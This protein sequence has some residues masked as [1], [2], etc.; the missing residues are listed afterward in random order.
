MAKVPIPI[1]KRHPFCVKCGARMTKRGTNHLIYGCGTTFN[2]HY[3]HWN[4]RC[5]RPDTAFP[6]YLATC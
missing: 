3:Q 4:H 2:I 1:V 5:T 6:W